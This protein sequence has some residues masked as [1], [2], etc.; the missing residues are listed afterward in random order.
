[1]KTTS[2]SEIEKMSWDWRGF[3]G[4]GAFKAGFKA[5]EAKMLAEASEG[6]EEWWRSFFYT[7][8][9]IA[10]GSIFSREIIEAFTAGAMSQARKDAEEIATLRSLKSSMSDVI[11]A[12]SARIKQLEMV[13]AKINDDHWFMINLIERYASDKNQCLADILERM[14][15]RKPLM[16]KALKQGGEG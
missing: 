13:V 1:M 16:E 14:K 3:S 4:Q 8:P 11:D 5:C 10:E 15:F 6:F 12:K 7:D 2:E 9:P